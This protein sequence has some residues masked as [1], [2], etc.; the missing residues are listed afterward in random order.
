LLVVLEQGLRTSALALVYSHAAEYAIPVWWSSTHARKIDTV[1]NDSMRIITGCLC[2][3][4]MEL[5]TALGD[6]STETA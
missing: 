5:L 6:C 4:L 1:F 3:T 2:P